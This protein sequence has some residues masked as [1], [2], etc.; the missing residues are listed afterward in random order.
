MKIIGRRPELALLSETLGS[1]KPE[2][3]N[4]WTVLIDFIASTYRIWF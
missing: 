2:S 1:D 3:T 4:F